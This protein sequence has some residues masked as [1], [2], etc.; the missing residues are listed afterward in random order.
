MLSLSLKKETVFF[1]ET[2]ISTY[3]STQPKTTSTCIKL[4]FIKDKL[5]SLQWRE[6][7]RSGVTLVREKHVLMEH[8][9]R[10]R[11][12]NSVTVHDVDFQYWLKHQREARANLVSLQ[13]LLRWHYSPIRTPILC[14]HKTDSGLHSVMWQDLSDDQV[15]P[16]KACS[17]YSQRNRQKYSKSLTLLSRCWQIW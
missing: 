14:N 3:E 15:N 10:S 1:S 6:M 11:R 4:L 12:L 13:F 16:Y 9:Q 7:L 2:L 5:Q 8:T 17:R